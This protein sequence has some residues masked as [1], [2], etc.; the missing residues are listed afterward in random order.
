MC[1]VCVGTRTCIRAL[2]CFLCCLVFNIATRTLH[3]P[4][5]CNSQCNWSSQSPVLSC[6]K[7]CKAATSAGALFWECTA[8]DVHNAEVY[9]C[10]TGWVSHVFLKLKSCS[11]SWITNCILQNRERGLQIYR[12]VLYKSRGFYDFLGEIL[13]ASLQDRYFYMI[14]CMSTLKPGLCVI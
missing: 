2:W 1:H 10:T 9:T 8:R 12:K 4:Q 6:M 3:P 5:V 7:L 13:Q 14:V 11:E